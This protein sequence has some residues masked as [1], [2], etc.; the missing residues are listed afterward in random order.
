MKNK[1]LNVLLILLAVMCLTGCGEK[2]EESNRQERNNQETNKISDIEEKKKDDNID[3]IS[4][5]LTYINNKEYDKAVELIDA[6]KINELMKINLP[7]EEFSKALNRSFNSENSV[8]QYDV[9]SLRNVSKED[10]L[11]EMSKMDENELLK[12]RKDLIDLFDGY[13]LYMVEV[14]QTYNDEKI[15]IHDV[16]FV[17]DSTICGT[18]FINGL[19]SYYYG[20]VYNRPGK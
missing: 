4:S 14:E 18:I 2:K 16:V 10:L 12:N 8:I 1:I 17:N 6:D 13:D 20:A 5:F 19:F 11:D 3:N 7:T 15:N 9:K